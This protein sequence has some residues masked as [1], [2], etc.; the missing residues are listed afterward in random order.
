MKCVWRGER[1]LGDL[2]KKNRMNPGARFMLRLSNFLLVF[3]VG[4]C[5]VRWHAY[6]RGV[7]ALQNSPWG[8]SDV[9]T[10]GKA[11]SAVGRELLAHIFFTCLR[12]VVLFAH[13]YP[14]NTR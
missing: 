6:T 14:L 5:C 11:V 3:R 8:V 12:H 2:D 4:F 13:I 10:S 7:T 1:G 9:K